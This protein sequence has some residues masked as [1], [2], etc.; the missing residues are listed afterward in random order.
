M[1]LGTVVSIDDPEGLGCV[2]V[3]IPNV[4]TESG[5]AFPFGVWA[6]EKRGSPQP[7][8]IGAKVACWWFGGQRDGVMGYLCGMWHRN[9]TPSGYAPDK[10]VWQNDKMRVEVDTTSSTPGLRIS[11]LGSDGDS[12]GTDVVLELDFAT[13]QVEIKGLTGFNLEAAGYGRIS[14]G[15]LTLN[16]RPVGPGEKPI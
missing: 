15:V 13:R 16:G 3:R 6:G 8:P 1:Y 5:W 2:K 9:W 12:A 10:W 7:P 4:T 11:N 14:A